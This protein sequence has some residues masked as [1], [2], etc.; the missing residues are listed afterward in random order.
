ML[1][2]RHSRRVQIINGL[3]PELLGRA[4]AGERIGTVI[5]APQGGRTDAR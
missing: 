4:L 5:E 1:H 3:K 2:A